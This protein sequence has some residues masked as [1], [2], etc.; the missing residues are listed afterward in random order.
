MVQLS[1]SVM[2]ARGF[3]RVYGQHGKSESYVRHTP[4]DSGQL[5]VEDVVI[6]L[7]PRFPRGIR[8]TVE[9]QDFNGAR[10]EYSQ[11]HPWKTIKETGADK[12]ITATVNKTHELLKKQ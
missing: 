9:M 5:N 10:Q 3:Q 2:A 11:F 4:E 6:Q 12:A 1:D 8:V 7:I